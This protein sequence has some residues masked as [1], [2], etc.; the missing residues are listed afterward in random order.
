[1]ARIA[2]GYGAGR[3][4]SDAL[5]LAATLGRPLG[6][7]LE[8]VVADGD[9]GSEDD[10]ASALDQAIGGDLPRRMVIDPRP[11][12]A[13]LLELAT[14]DRGIEMIVIGSTPEAGLGRVR[15]GR[16][17]SRLLSGAPCPVAIAPASFGASE[18]APE[19]P[20]VIEVGFDGSAEA[21]AA[22]ALATRIAI[23]AGATLRVVAVGSPAPADAQY[24]GPVGAT[25]VSTGFDLQ[26]RLHEAVAELPDELRAL[27]IFSHGNAPGVLL[28]RAEE[29]V[30]LLIVGSRGHGRLG[31]ALLGSTSRAVLASAACPVIVVSRPSISR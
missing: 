21:S 22:L 6:A 14:A 11:T 5:A 26:E 23:A 7:E 29:G 16:L 13:V 17:L 15:S 3:G 25:A 28:E 24:S 31:S 18:P 9:E 27:A 8:L 20:R 2:V 30:D 10:L 19:P 12:A 4:G 1:M